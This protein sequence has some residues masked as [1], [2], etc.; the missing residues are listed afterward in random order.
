MVNKFSIDFNHVP[1]TES[2]MIEWT[3]YLTIWKDNGWPS[4]AVFIA[5]WLRRH[6]VIEH[7]STLYHNMDECITKWSYATKL[8]IQR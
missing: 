4:P 8:N 5:K 7:D 1:L 2:R 6:G 3:V